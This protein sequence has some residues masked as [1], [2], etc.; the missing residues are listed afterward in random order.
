MVLRLTEERVTASDP[1]EVILKYVCV[2]F[3][4][5]GGVEEHRSGLLLGRTLAGVVG[6]KDGWRLGS[7]GASTKTGGEMSEGSS[8]TGL[9][10]QCFHL[11][12]RFWEWG[13]EFNEALAK[14]LELGEKGIETEGGIL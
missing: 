5:G 7:G 10:L 12:C 8:K 2:R 4:D 6:G 11:N 13:N 3:L 1:E 14:F 9:L